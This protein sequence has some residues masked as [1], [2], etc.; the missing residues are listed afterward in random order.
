MGAYRVIYEIDD[1]GQCVT[2]L[3][4]IVRMFIADVRSPCEASR[5]H[6]NGKLLN[7]SER[8]RHIELC[9]AMRV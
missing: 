4:V 9:Q 1:A 5:S 6:M 3:Q 8:K 2:V 7:G